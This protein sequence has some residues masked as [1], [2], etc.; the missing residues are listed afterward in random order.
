MSLLLLV[1]SGAGTA[2]AD[3]VS[4]MTPSTASY[5]VGDSGYIDLMIYSTS[6]DALDSYF[7]GVNIAGGTGLTFRDPQSESFLSDGNYVFAGRSS[8]VIN[9]FP[10]TIPGLG[11]SEISVGDFSEDP[12]SPFTPLPVNLPN[13]GSPNLLARL[14]FD[15]NAAGVFDFTLDPGSSFS[16]ELF[17]DFA[18]TSSGTSVTVNSTAAVPEPTSMTLLGAAL[19]GAGW[20]Q[21][22]RRRKATSES[23]AA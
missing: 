13:A 21:R 16:D 5:N 19:L 14:E 1:C 8:N 12:G 9:M 10:A 15:T 23:V 6:A 2:S 4:T 18:F 20:H 3:I 22:R 17:N 7:A 11:G